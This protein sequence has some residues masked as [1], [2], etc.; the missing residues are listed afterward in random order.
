MAGMLFC[1]QGVDAAASSESRCRVY[2]TAR[3]WSSTGWR[4]QR[5][6][7]TIQAPRRAGETAQ[8]AVLRVGCYTVAGVERRRKRSFSLG[9]GAVARPSHIVT[10]RLSGGKRMAGRRV[11]RQRLRRRSGDAAPRSRDH[12]TDRRMMM[13]KGGAPRPSVGSGRDRG[14]AVA[15]TPQKLSGRH[16]ATL[17]LRGSVSCAVVKQERDGKCRGGRVLGD[18]FFRCWARSL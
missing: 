4:G 13:S 10:R 6:R 11:P 9:A 16:C 7:G 8:R 5:D 15:V 18:Q 14:R 12:M 2:R 1:E 3:D 17:V